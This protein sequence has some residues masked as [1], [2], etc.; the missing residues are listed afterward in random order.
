V[1]LSQRQRPRFS[2]FLSFWPG[3]PNEA[4]T[5]GILAAINLRRRGPSWRCH[6]G[7]FARRHQH[8]PVVPNCFDSARFIWGATLG[9]PT[10]DSI[11]AAL[12]ESQDGLTRWDIHDH[13]GRNKTA[14]EID[15]A[16]RVLTE[17]ALIRYAKE[18]SGGRPTTRYWTL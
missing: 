7:P 12:R 3:L 17:R 15:R 16:I 2:L 6:N 10:A 4:V 5:A 13:F 8:K 18:E 9:D 14:S 1:S 11:L